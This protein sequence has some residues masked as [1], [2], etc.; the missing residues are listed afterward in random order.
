MSR[1]QEKLRKVG[2]VEIRDVSLYRMDT[3]NLNA[4][5]SFKSKNKISI[6][7]IAFPLSQYILIY[8]HVPERL[9]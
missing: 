2:E 1:F 3:R 7:N 5:L 9:N 8:I 6:E 4:I